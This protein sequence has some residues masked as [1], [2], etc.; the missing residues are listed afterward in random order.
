MHF[1]ITRKFTKTLHAKKVTT[2]KTK[3]SKQKEKGNQDETKHL[4]E[5]RAEHE[6]QTQA[7]KSWANVKREVR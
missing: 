5:N 4:H 3:L 1:K 7:H 6:T 2:K